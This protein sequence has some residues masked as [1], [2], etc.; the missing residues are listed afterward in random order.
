MTKLSEQWASL[1]DSVGGCCFF[2]WSPPYCVV[3][4]VQPLMRSS[5][6]TWWHLQVCHHCLLS[7]FSPAYTVSCL[8]SGW[9]YSTCVFV[10]RK[11]RL[12][13][14]KEPKQQKKK[15]TFGSDQS[16]RT[17][18]NL[19]GVNMSSDLTVIF[20]LSSLWP[21]YICWYRFWLQPTSIK[22]CGFNKHSTHLYVSN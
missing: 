3:P 20:F 8:M 22:R 2:D 12:Q 4:P 21:I 16:R 7:W 10:L 19:P 1:F 11:S 6:V 17:I 14:E 5:K 15:N 18:K 13:R 9:P